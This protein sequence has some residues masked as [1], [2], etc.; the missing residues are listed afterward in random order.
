MRRR[1]SQQLRRDFDLS[2][3]GPATQELAQSMHAWLANLP[4]A[5]L[6][7]IRAIG[8]GAAMFYLELDGKPYD[9][10]VEPVMPEAF[11][12]VSAAENTDH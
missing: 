11:A 9:V 5:R 3:R 6:T 4:G 10:I 2:D 7:G 1:M 12:R 8:S